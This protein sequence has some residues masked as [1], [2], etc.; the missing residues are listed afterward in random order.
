MASGYFPVD[1]QLDPLGKKL[2]QIA[3]D[4]SAA[5]SDGWDLVHENDQYDNAA[6]DGMA[7]GELGMALELIKRNIKPPPKPDYEGFAKQALA[8]IQKY[9]PSDSGVTEGAAFSELLALID[10]HPALIAL[11][12]AGKP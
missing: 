9:L 10:T 7:V 12:K 4:L 8:I 3:D 11:S 6:N 5:I 1:P 2:Q